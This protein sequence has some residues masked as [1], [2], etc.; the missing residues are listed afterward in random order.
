MSRLFGIAVVLFC[1]EIGL[2]LI[3]VP[4]SAFWDANVFLSYVPRLRTLL[5]HPL[6][7]TA[8]TALGCLNCAIGVSEIRR[9]FGSPARHRTET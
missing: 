6:A 7:R 3:F 1:F 8:V 5:L 9:K 4:W 2:F